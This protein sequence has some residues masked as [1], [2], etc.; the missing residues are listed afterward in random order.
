MNQ[1]CTVATYAFTQT[2][3][4]ALLQ[5][6]Y[7]LPKFERNA[8]AEFMLSNFQDWM[9]AHFELK[10]SQLNFLKNL[11]A[12]TLSLTAAACSF[13]LANQLPIYLEK[14]AKITPDPEPEPPF[15]TLRTSSNLKSNSANDGSWSVSGY[16]TVSIGYGKD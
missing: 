2:G 9:A 13:A 1:N 11:N 3:V 10:P 16:V 15:K 14:Q 8:E 7:D 5:E 6:I 12:E 4:D